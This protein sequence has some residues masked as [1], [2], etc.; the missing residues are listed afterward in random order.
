MSY[1]TILHDLALEHR[2][3]IPRS[4]ARHRGVPDATFYRWSR[5]GLLLPCQPGVWRLR[6]S[7]PSWEQGMLAAVLAAGHGAAVSHRSAARLRGLTD[8]ADRAPFDISVPRD[9]K[10]RLRDVVVHRSLDL[11]PRHV[12]MLD[13]LPV[14]TVERTLADL[15]DVVPRRHVAWA[16]ERGVI[17]RSTTIDRLW[18]FLDELG[19]QGRNG[20]GALREALESWLFDGRPPDSVLEVIFAR[21]CHDHGLPCPEYQV[22]IGLPGGE[23]ARVDALWRGAR[24]MVEVDGLHAHASAVQL[25]RDLRR[26]NGLVALGYRVLRYT[27]HDV[28][29]EPRVVAHD[30]RVELAGRAV[31]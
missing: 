7:P 13:G 15:G 1:D 23:K 8:D 10:P 31:G 24:L 26:Q 20:R 18:S 30:L 5:S 25:Q 28:V 16:M 11:V 19:R 3:L 22:S 21:L 27:W 29:R 9:R 14:T 6:S 2:G 4:I 17:S 12:T